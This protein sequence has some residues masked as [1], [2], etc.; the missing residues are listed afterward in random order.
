MPDPRPERHSRPLRWLERLFLIAGAAALIWCVA[1]VTDGAIAQWN[2]R[3][4][5]EIAMAAHAIAPPPLETSAAARSPHL[6]PDVGAVIAALSIP[7]VEL[8]AMVLHGSDALTLRRGPGHL[9]HTADPGDAG[10]VVIAGHR[11]SFFRPL[12][13]IR[14]GDDIFLDTTEGQFHYQVTSLQV[15]GP[16][17]VSVLAPTREEVLTLI[18]CYPFWVLGNAPDR[19]VVRA[20]RVRDQAS[21]RL[22]GRH[23]PP[24]E[25]VDAPTL[26]TV[27]V[28]AK[29][30]MRAATPKD[31]ESGVREAVARYLR[32]NGVPPASCTV[33]VSDDL[34]TADCASVAQLSSDSQSARMFSLERTNGAWVIRSIEL[35]PRQ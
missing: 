9:E 32:V 4:A 33:A 29:I 5:L 35:A 25:W 28:K 14:L 18:T 22:V 10:N 21:P 15:V 20:A 3:T 34:A 8:S 31:D 7:R 24:L 13:N 12:R 27:R 17:D 16:R 2:A 23:L 6:P 1:I 19:F 30:V 11:D 26:D